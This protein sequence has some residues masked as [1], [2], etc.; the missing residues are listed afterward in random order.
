MRIWLIEPYFGGSH[1][2]WAEGYRRHSRH[3]VELITHE[4]RFWK[5]R[6]QGAHLTLSA[7]AAS[8]PGP[9][10]VVL[11]SSMLNLAG[12]LGAARRSVGDAPVVVYLHE[13]QLA[14][15]RSPLDRA[16]AAY[17]MVNWTSASVADLVLFN[18]AYHR[19]RFFSLLPAFLHQFPDHRHD[20]LVAAVRG[21][22]EVIPVGVDLAEVPRGAE[23]GEPPLIVWNHR[24]EHDKGIA[25]LAAAVRALVDTGANFRMAICG[26]QFVSVPDA[27]ASL[28]GLLGDR[29]IQFGFAPEPEYR[30]LLADAAITL[31]TAFQEFFGV[32]VVEAMS[33]GAVPVLPNRLV[34]RERAP[35]RRCLYADDPVPTLE[36]LLG[37]PEVR[38]R[39]GA[40]AQEEVAR[41]AWPVVAGQ[42]DDR[43]EALR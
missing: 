40:A 17:P 13:N 28:P 12:F 22:A 31:S 34:Y 14:Y 4:A 36:W 5:W 42:M 29:L 9:P 43:L 24:W 20:D 25:E 26:E 10:D 38:A 16:D 37:D 32:A 11:A 35:D 18:S 23:K 6:M 15:P 3:E 1:R 2:A 8:L 41:F 21:R 33:A 19:D 39:L 30:A 7:A 27:F